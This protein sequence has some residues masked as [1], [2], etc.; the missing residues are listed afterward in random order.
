M[1]GVLGLALIALLG[2]FVFRHVNKPEASGGMIGHSN[3]SGD[4]G[5]LNPEM[6]AA[7]GG[8]PSGQHVSYLP[9]QLTGPTVG[10]GGGSGGYHKYVQVIGVNCKCG[11][12]FAS[13]YSSR[14]SSSF[15]PAQ[16]YQN[17]QPQ[18]RYSGMPE[19]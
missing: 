4:G 13:I 11:I 19:V 9:N 3:D 1:G 10:S 17:T 12:L 18:G 7:G 8:V 5:K 15:P 2:F 16:G 6:A 14:D